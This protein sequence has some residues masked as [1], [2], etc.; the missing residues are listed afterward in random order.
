MEFNGNVTMLA[1][2]DDLVILGDSHHEVIQT[3]KKL[4]AS[5]QNL[6]LI[7]NKIKI[8]NR[9]HSNGLPHVHKG[10]FDNRTIHF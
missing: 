3:V 2:V 1:F 4:I 5:S 6:S 8:K 9:V 10:Q 7:I